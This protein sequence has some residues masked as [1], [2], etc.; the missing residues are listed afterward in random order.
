MKIAIIFIGTNKYINFFQGYRESLEKF[1][2]PTC[3]KTYFAFTDQPEHK[4]FQHKNVI[5]TK[6][7]HEPWPYV[8]LYRFKYM[9]KKESLLKS[10]DKV[11][12]VDADLFANQEITADHLFRHKKNLIGV[13]HPGWFGKPWVGAFETDTRCRANI[14]DG[15]YDL[16][17]YRQGCF[18]GGNSQSIML[19]AA[20][21]EKRVDED[22]RDGIVACWH[23]E[24]HLNKYLIE[25]QEDVF[26]LHPGFAQPESPDYDHLR[27]IFPTMMIHLDKNYS[28]FPRF[29][30]VK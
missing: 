6:I 30:G 13:Q 19:M 24:S 23:D 7:E 25:N 9:M 15:N 14:F 26:T 10:Y 22:L 27:S 1:F 21:L 8:T 2:L 12:F 16:S 5:T 11:F 17:Y 18:W 29:E 4:I 20:T 28:D 3:E